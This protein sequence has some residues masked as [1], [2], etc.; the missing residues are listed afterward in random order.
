MGTGGTVTEPVDKYPGSWWWYD[1]GGSK[2]NFSPELF[3]GGMKEGYAPLENDMIQQCKKA[4]TQ[5]GGEVPG[6]ASNW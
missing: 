2:K 6:V 4:G 3:V 5:G 1:Y